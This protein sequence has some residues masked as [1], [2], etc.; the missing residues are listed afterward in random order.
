MKDQSLPFNLES[1]LS[2][3]LLDFLAD[4][5]EN[6]LAAAFADSLLAAGTCGLR[7][8]AYIKFVQGE[9]SPALALVALSEPRKARLLL[10]RIVAQ[11]ADIDVRN[12][13][14]PFRGAPP[15]AAVTFLA[16]SIACLADDLTIDDLT[17]DERQRSE[18]Y[19][20][21][22]SLMLARTYPNADKF[23]M[24]DGYFDHLARLALWWTRTGGA[25]DWLDLRSATDSESGWQ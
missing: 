21:V 7:C 23:S 13:R 4:P 8:W 10:E 16:R 5:E 1:K 19:G 14:E 25:V 9:E 6:A 17:D 3:E 20:V 24:F 2:L 15:E 22:L 18:I 12:G 11:I